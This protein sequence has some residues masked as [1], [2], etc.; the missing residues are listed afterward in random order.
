[1]GDV[2]ASG[3]KSH[4]R[5]WARKTSGGEGAGP[6]RKRGSEGLGFPSMAAG[7]SGMF[8]LYLPWEERKRPREEPF[9]A[10]PV[11]RSGAW[12][13]PGSVSSSH[14]EKREQASEEG[15]ACRVTISHKAKTGTTLGWQPHQEPH[16][17]SCPLE[18]RGAPARHVEPPPLSPWRAGCS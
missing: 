17:L 13:P 1:M 4:G 6:G 14:V 16:R 10:E 3:L 9:P 8:L 5:R 12:N 7:E 18:P 15:R 11:V 2:E